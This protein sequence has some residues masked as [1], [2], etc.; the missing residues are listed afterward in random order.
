MD[1]VQGC[2]A[3]ETIYASS[4][5]STV[6]KVAGETTRTRDLSTLYPR[7]ISPSGICCMKL[8]MTLQR[9]WA[10]ML[11]KKISDISNAARN[12]DEVVADK[13]VDETGRTDI[14]VLKAVNCCWPVDPWP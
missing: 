8:W 12:L 4:N 14:S 9:L 11:W 5:M 2:T 7:A 13:V 3:T 1:F 10:N 6:L